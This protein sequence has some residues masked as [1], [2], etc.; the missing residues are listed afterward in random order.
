[1]V[2]QS[3]NSVLAISPDRKDNHREH[4]DKESF[5]WTIGRNY[6]WFDAEGRELFLGLVHTLGWGGLRVS[7]QTPTPTASTPNPYASTARCPVW[8]AHPW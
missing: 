8:M 1:V 4:K 2:A 3:G 6:S 7:L 5:H